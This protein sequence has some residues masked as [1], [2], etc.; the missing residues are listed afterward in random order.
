MLGALYCLMWGWMCLTSVLFL[1]LVT[2]H[3][4]MGSTCSVYV[5]SNATWEVICLLNSLLATLSVL[6]L[7]CS[8][9]VDS[10]MT[11]VLG[12]VL[13]RWCIFAF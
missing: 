6:L 13:R 7:H 12:P 5:L 9:A 8:G 3:L 10:L 1:H 2:M 11:S 4:G